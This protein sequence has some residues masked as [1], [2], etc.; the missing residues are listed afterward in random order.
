MVIR[1]DFRDDGAW[2]ALKLALSLPWG[3]EEFEPHA[4][5]VDAPFTPT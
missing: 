5:V 3:P 2:V 1:T 4:H